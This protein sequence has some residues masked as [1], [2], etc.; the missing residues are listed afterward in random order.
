MKKAAC[1][2][3]IE[4]QAAFYCA[5]FMF[6]DGFHVSKAANPCSNSVR[7]NN[8]PK[9]SNTDIHQLAKIKSFDRWQ[10]ALE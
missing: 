9:I 3:E 4:V 8:R 5:D 6:S 2:L 1:T 7:I 10:P